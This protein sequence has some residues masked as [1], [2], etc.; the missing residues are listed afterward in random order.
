MYVFSSVFKNPTCGKRW[1][2]LSL[3]YIPAHIQAPRGRDHQYQRAQKPISLPSVP[4]CHTLALDENAIALL[5]T[6]T[7]DQRS[8]V[9]IILHAGHRTSRRL[10][11][12]RPWS[13]N[14]TEEPRGGCTGSQGGLLTPSS[15]VSVPDQYLDAGYVVVEAS[16]L[17]FRPPRVAGADRR[18]GQSNPIFVI[19]PSMCPWCIGYVSLALGTR[20]SVDGAA[21]A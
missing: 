5:G 13:S 20:A 6:Q 21:Q 12:P 18:Q 14:R 16:R 7:W 19:H 1:L 9:Y 3:M 2:C 10:P 17:S 8:I 11:Q 4:S 15:L